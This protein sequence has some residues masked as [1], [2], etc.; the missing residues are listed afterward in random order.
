MT[1]AGHAYH[2]TTYGRPSFERHRRSIDRKLLAQ[3]DVQLQRLAE[4]PQDRPIWAQDLL[5][6]ARAVFLADKLSL[7][8]GSADRWTR[9]IDLSVQV[10]EF[11]RW[12]D[13]ALRLLTELTEA[14]T[15][16]KWHI[17]VHPGA[18][19][20]PHQNR[21]HSPQAAEEVALFSG[22]LDSSAYAAERARA[23]GGELLLVSYYEP[24][25]ASQQEAVLAAIHELSSRAVRQSRSPQQI[26]ARQELEPSARSRGLLYTATAV[27]L[28]AAHGVAQVA[29]P[30]NGQLALNPALTP[31]RVAAC[32]TRSVHPY[33]LSLLNALIHEVGGSVTVV[34]PYLHLTKGEVC[35]RALAAG[36]TPTTLTHATMSC[37]R[38]PRNQPELQCGHCYPCLVRR[39]G[40]LAA[41]GSDGTPY[42]KNVWAVADRSDAAAD[43]RALHRWLTHPFGVRDL[44]T[45]MPLP[46]GTNLGP[47]VGVVQRGREEMARMF[48]DAG[49]TTAPAAAVAFWPGMGAGCRGMPEP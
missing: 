47:L 48:A 15:S 39:S 6:V 23:S 3:A 40:L 10:A 41:L 9:R 4:V 46:E 1:A 42:A 26:K 21:I 32:S 36:L 12:T 43:R 14:L 22:G 28:A 38:P 25:W 35:E 11:D 20:W 16:D 33:T 7:R 49:V 27:Y 8:S 44:F 5:Q 29:V 17:R 13:R 37:G 24:Q 19:A 45:D 2:Y 18:T 34:N 31:A 30:E